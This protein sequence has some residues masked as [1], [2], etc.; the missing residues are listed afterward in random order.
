VNRS[1]FFQLAVKTGLREPRA[2]PRNDPA[3]DHAEQDK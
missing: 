1:L 2:K 3:E